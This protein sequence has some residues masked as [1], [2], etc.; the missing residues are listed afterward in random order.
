MA[1]SS[2]LAHIIN[3]CEL[4]RSDHDE[5]CNIQATSVVAEP[6]LLKRMNIKKKHKI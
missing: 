5:I 1:S 3:R 2:T 6:S 4:S